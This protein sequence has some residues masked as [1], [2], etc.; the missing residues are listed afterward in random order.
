MLIAKLIFWSHAVLVLTTTLHWVF[1][2][3]F[4]DIEPIT[5]VLSGWIFLLYMLIAKLIF[6]SHALHW[7]FLLA[8]R[9]IEPITCVLSGWIFLLYTLIAKWS[10]AVLVLT[11]T[12]HRVFLL[13][14]RECYIAAHEFWVL[15]IYFMCS[16]VSGEDRYVLLGTNDFWLPLRQQWDKCHLSGSINWSALKTVCANVYFVDELHCYIKVA[17]GYN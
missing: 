4:R 2:L 6:W 12:L 13:V 9:D 15:L 17:L 5:C 3:A 7:V 1:L 16:V 14:F 8:F 11:T 10:H